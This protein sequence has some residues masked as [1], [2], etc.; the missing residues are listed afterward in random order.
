MRTKAILL[1]AAVG[2]VAVGNTTAQVYSA[3]AVGYVN[4]SLVAGL[5]ILAN[6][7]NQPDNDL[8]NTL[9]MTDA[10]IGATV[11]RFDESV[12]SFGVP[13]QYL[14]SAGGWL[15][16][17]PDPAWLVLNPGE[18][19][20]LELFV[21]VSITWVGEVPQGDLVNPL[22]ENG[23]LAMRSSQ[24]PQEAPV[25]QPGVGLE[26][27]GVTGDTLF[28]FDTAA[29]QYKQPYQFIEGL[30]WASA[31]PGEETDF[32]GPMIPVATGFFVQ[33]VAPTGPSWDRSF[34]VNN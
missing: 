33:R 22:P 5:Q 16:A 28:I 2:A 25:G 14:G 8:N 1:A 9:V 32:D 21:P 30:G 29:Q 4:Q 23:A 12:N 24:V 3:N 17:N 13:I 6:P 18:A 10:Q 19:F 26:F 20:F 34:S 11:F 7:L 27:A 31:N 15:S